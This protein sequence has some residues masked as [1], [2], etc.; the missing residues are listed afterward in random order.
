MLP[1]GALDDPG[2]DGP[3]LAERGGVVQV[4]LLVVQ[5]AG[6][7]RR[8][9]R[10]RLASSRRW[11]RGGGS[12]P[13]PARV[14]PCRILRAWSATHSSAAGSPLSKKD[15]A[16]F[17]RYSSTWMKSMHDRD[18]DAA[19]VGLGGDG[20]DLGVVPVDQDDPFPLV[21]RVAAF[22]LIEGG[23]D[24]GGDVIGDRG[25]QPLAPRLRLPRLSL[26][27]RLRFAWAFFFRFCAGVADDVLA[28]CAGPG[29]RRRRR[30]ARPSA[31]GRV[32]SPGDS[33][34][35]SLLLRRGG[36]FRGGGAQRARQH[37]DALPVEGQHQRASRPAPGSITRCR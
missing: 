18:R 7:I 4:V 34:V 8:R 24:D 29:R 1:A 19:A 33:R 22:A 21:L 20:L 5:V 27:L 31:C 3:A 10:A 15:Q 25:G 28:A 9:R 2:G 11:W 16:A 32:F 37:H 36:G 30:P 35:A 26:T 23:G 13:R 12:R 17:H 6:G 14:L